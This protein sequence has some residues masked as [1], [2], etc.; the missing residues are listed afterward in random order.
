MQ[1]VNP[2]MALSERMFVGDSV[3]TSVPMGQTVGL[4][5]GVQ[6]VIGADIL[7]TVAQKEKIKIRKRKNPHH[8]PGHRL[9]QC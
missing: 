1:M 7:L 2:G 9:H 4:I 8:K 6:S 3:K 5:T